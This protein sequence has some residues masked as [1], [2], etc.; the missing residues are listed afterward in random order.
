MEVGSVAA[1]TRSVVVV[2]ECLE[3]KA[4]DPAAALGV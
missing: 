2:A 4:S 1:A 3:V